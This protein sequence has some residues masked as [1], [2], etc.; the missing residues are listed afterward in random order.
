MSDI[1]TA[2]VNIVPEAN[3]IKSKMA[4][5]VNPAA[6]VTGAKAGKLMG[7]KI[8]A[9]VGAAAIGAAV[10]T[11]LKKSISEGAELEQSIGGIET[12]FK[13]SADAVIKNAKQAYKTAG[14]SAN[15]YMQ[16]VTS[17]SAGLIKSMGGNTKAA[18]KVADTAMVDMSDNANKMG[19]D[20]ASIQNAYQGFAKQNYTMLD[21]LKLGYGGTKTEMERL[22][23]DAGK[24]SGIKYDISNLSDVYSAIHV[25][26]QDL[27][28]TG[29]TAEEAAHTLSGSFGS[30]KAAFSDFMGNLALGK[31]VDKSMANLVKA[32]ETFLIGNLI[33]A[34]GRVFKSLPSA[35]KAAINTDT[36]KSIPEMVDN[37]ADKFDQYAPVI[38]EKGADL[39][40][41]LGAGLIKALPSIISIMGKIINGILKIVVGLPAILLARGMMA[42]GKFGLGLL[43]GFNNAVGKVKAAIDKILE[44]IKN[45][46]EK[47][48]GFFPI[49]VGKILSNIKLPH[50]SVSGGKAPWGFGGAGKMPS[51]SVKW[52][53]QGAIMTKPTLFAGGER[54]HEAILPLTPFWEKLDKALGNGRSITNNI[55]VYS[56]DGTQ[57]AHDF[58]TVMEQEAR[59]Y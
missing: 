43:K 34:I 58:M 36:V 45:V 39:A 14:I 27:H 21:N 16:N 57:F 7:L 8:A 6:D 32:T 3:G 48:K 51:V 40:M 5:I 12:L 26:Q 53:A 55:T 38:A 2:Y 13:G 56:D 49:D 42:A 22:L 1:G 35:M 50:F 41:K 29:T 15:E 24:I 54:G 44:P 9:G 20:M 25:I 46:V 30:M 11:G 31:D 19:T 33:P 4:G 59:A 17:F 52:F 23:E 37:L 10:V 47:I 18:V 28:I